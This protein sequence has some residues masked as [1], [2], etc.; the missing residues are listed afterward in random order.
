VTPTASPKFRLRNLFKFKRSVNA[1]PSAA[2][3][4]GTTGASPTPSPKF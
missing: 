3:I 2:P 1:S 4:T